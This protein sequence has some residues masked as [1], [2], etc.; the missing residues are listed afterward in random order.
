MSSDD[1]S[2]TTPTESSSVATSL[3]GGMYN[4]TDSSSC[5]V[6][7]PPKEFKTASTS[8]DSIH[9]Q[10]NLDTSSGVQST[11]LNSNFEEHIDHVKESSSSTNTIIQHSSLNNCN[12]SEDSSVLESISNEHDDEER[13]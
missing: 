2:S 13:I 10:E 1:T 6:E 8:T 7:N 11:S 5:P 3:K 12:I 4:A 9:P